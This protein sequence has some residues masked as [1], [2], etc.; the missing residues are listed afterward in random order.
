MDDLRKDQAFA[1]RI[2]T[3][4]G[5]ARSMAYGALEAAKVGNYQEADELLEKAEEASAEAHRVQADLLAAEAN[6][7]DIKTSII[8]VHAQD[9]F[10]TSMLAIELIREIIDLHKKVGG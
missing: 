2:I 8:L 9:H 1:F 3:A 7:E 5:D 4:S 10:M 6:G